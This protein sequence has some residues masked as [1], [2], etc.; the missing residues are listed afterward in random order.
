LNINLEKD[1]HSNLFVYKTDHNLYNKWGNNVLKAKEFIKNFDEA[2]KK[3]QDKL[4]KLLKD[5]ETNNYCLKENCCAVNFKSPIKKFFG[6][7]RY[8][9][10]L[11]K[12]R[13]KET[14]DQ[15]CIRFI[16]LVADD[17][18]N[19]KIG[20]RIDRGETYY[21]LNE[22]NEKDLIRIPIEEKKVYSQLINKKL[23]LYKIEPSKYLKESFIFTFGR[24]SFHKLLGKR[25][26]PID[27]KEDIEM[28][29]FR[30]RFRSLKE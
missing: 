2:R 18:R 27:M 14:D 19:E 10:D 23:F 3:L 4:D 13:C 25:I 9:Y 5:I 12:D 28:Y 22:K 29:K 17:I 11:W 20:N 24:R 21:G 7:V 8:E 30:S 1:P 16:Y 26:K 6:E 15:Q